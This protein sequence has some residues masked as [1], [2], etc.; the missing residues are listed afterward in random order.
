MGFLFYY[1]SI[2]I[3]WKL[4]FPRLLSL[5]Q[6]SDRPNL[7]LNWMGEVNARLSLRFQ[8]WDS[9][10]STHLLPVSFTQRC[11][12]VLPRRRLI[13]TPTCVHSLTMISMA[14][15]IHANNSTSETWWDLILYFWLS[16]LNF[17]QSNQPLGGQKARH[18]M[19]VFI[20]LTSPW[21]KGSQHLKLLNSPPVA[22]PCSLRE[23]CRNISNN[24]IPCYFVV[25]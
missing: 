24:L 2:K 1:F 19:G 5:L 6:K 7:Q 16:C 22:T 4:P 23:I 9:K 3:Y 11:I 25:S 12:S 20:L 17:P 8:N 21:G 14:G 18:Q 15:Y 10:Q 13:N